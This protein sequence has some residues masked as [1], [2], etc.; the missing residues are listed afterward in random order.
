MLSWEICYET[1][2]GLPPIL[3]FTL[4]VRLSSQ[5]LIHSPDVLNSPGWAGA[6]AGSREHSPALPHGGQ[7]S[8]Y[9]SMAPA[10]HGLRPEGWSQSPGQD[11]NPGSGR[12]GVVRSI[13]LN[14]FLLIVFKVQFKR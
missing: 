14:I 2:T 11:L 8:G 4:F 6:E 7:E 1:I 12:V 5:A 9:V 13:R 3:F 10:S